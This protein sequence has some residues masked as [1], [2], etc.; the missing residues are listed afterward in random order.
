[1]TGT[2]F[3]CP[4]CRHALQLDVSSAG[5]SVACPACGQQVAVPASAIPAGR[6]AS[7]TVFGIL[8]IIFGTF[9][10]ICTPVGLVMANVFSEVAQYTTAYQAWMVASGI[11]GFI[12]AAV[13]LASGIGLLKGRNWARTGS[14]AYGWCTIAFSIVGIAVNVVMIN[15]GMLGGT[16]EEMLGSYV[17]TIAGGIGGLIYPI[18]LIIFMTR[19]GIIAA[20]D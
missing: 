16:T 8:N 4:Q 2:T 15:G 12:C 17:G 11:F 18:L 6:P 14:I 19:P 10:I 13:L 5:E 1:M 9:G 3:T 7:L 20:C